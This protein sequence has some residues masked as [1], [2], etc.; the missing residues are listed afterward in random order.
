M[1]RTMLHRRRNH[2]RLTAL[3]ENKSRLTY[4]EQE[5]ALLVAK[6]LSNQQI[7]RR[8]NVAEGTVKAHLSNIYQKLAI[9]NR[10]ELA[11]FTWRV[12]Q[13]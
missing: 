1:I 12:K 7:A 6:G 11:N 10:T 13:N 3:S 2:G 4:R 9:T 8:L 5:V